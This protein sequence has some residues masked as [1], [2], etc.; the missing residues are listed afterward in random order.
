MK[1]PHLPGL[2]DTVLRVDQ[3]Y[4]FAPEQKTGLQ[5]GRTQLIV[6]LGQAA[7]VLERGL[8][9][10]GILFRLGHAPLPRPTRRLK[11][12]LL[13]IIRVTS[14]CDR[15]VG[16]SARHL[17]VVS[18]TPIGQIS[19]RDERMCPHL[20]NLGQFRRQSCS[21]LGQAAGRFV[22]SGRSHARGPA[23]PWATNASENYPLIACCPK[24]SGTWWRAARQLRILS[25]KSRKSARTLK[26]AS[27]DPVFTEAVWLLVRIPQAAS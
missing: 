9:Q 25:T 20:H 16:V 17:A 7:Y 8:S 10:R 1:K 3:R 6:S 14:G 12:P 27:K 19:E 23:A 4:A 5:I 21:F 11:P 2:E 26:L 24:S 18:D 22:T 15:F 13:I